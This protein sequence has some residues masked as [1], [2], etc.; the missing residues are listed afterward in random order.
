[1]VIMRGVRIIAFYFFAIQLK[2]K[3]KFVNLL[4]NKDFYFI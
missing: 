4:T 3:L 2:V 1:M